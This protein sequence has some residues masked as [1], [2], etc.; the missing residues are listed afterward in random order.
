[1]PT[2]WSCDGIKDGRTP[3][4]AD[5][6]WTGPNGYTLPICATCCAYWRANAADDDWL[7]P[8][9]VESIR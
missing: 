6:W 5:Y 7:T 4:P 8:Q 2:C 1:M 9:R 3:P